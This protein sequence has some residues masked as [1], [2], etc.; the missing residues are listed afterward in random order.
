[1]VTIRKMNAEEPHVHHVNGNTGTKPEFSKKDGIMYC[2]SCGGE[3]LCDDG[4]CISCGKSKFLN[5]DTSEI[6]GGY[7]DLAKKNRLKEYYYK[8]RYSK[9]IVKMNEKRI[10]QQLMQNKDKVDIK[11]EIVDKIYGA[12]I[13]MKI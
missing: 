7:I 13:E 11:K 4:K 2:L 9:S 10:I 8:T 12:N 1:M 5:S 3:C 6:L